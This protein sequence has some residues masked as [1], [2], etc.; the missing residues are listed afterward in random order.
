MKRLGWDGNLSASYPSPASEVGFCLSRYR[1]WDTSRFSANAGTCKPIFLGKDG[2]PPAISMLL[3]SNIALCYLFQYYSTIQKHRLSPR[4][5]KSM[6][7]HAAV[8]LI[9]KA[10]HGDLIIC[11][12]WG[13]GVT[14]IL[15]S[16]AG[17]DMWDRGGS[18]G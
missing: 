1:R 16:R 6:R 15:H 12:R 7:I 17:A 5:I 4:L 14:L 13:G 18:P 11:G 8:G 10:G 2:L 3:L 9:V